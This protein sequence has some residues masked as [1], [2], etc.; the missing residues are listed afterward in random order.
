[1]RIK[2]TG[3]GFGI[4]VEGVDVHKNKLSVVQSSLAT[5]NAVRIYADNPYNKCCPQAIAFDCIHVNEEG[6]RLIIKGLQ[7]WLDEL[8]SEEDC[9]V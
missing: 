5:D 9:N 3:R 4:Y 1:M 7:L 2:S 8:N 6:A